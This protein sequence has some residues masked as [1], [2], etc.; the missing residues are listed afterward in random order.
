MVRFTVFCVIFVQ[1]KQDNF[2]YYRSDRE[3]IYV[4]IR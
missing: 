1:R 2:A 4:E 3:V